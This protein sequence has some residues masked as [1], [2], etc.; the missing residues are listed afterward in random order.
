M[1]SAC[2]LLPAACCLSIQLFCHRCPVSS[3]PVL[4]HRKGIK[5]HIRNII[6]VIRSQIKRYHRT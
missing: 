2:C 3:F 4:I 1:P 5:F 6:Q